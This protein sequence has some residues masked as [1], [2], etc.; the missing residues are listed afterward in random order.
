MGF[1]PLGVF[2]WPSARPLGVVE[3]QEATNINRLA[4]RIENVRGSL[5][6]NAQSVVGASQLGI[7]DTLQVRRA[8]QGLTTQDNWSRASSLET[9]SGLRLPFG[10]SVKINSNE[11][12]TERSGSSQDR[13]RVQRE[14]RFPRFNLNWGRAD[15]IPYIK[16]VI[17]S[18]QVNANWEKS[19]TSEGEGSL[20]RHNLITEGGSDEVRVSWN[21]RWRW[22]PTTTIEHVV[23]NAISTDFE[24]TSVESDSTAIDRPPRGR[25]ENKRSSTTFKVTYTL[26]PRSLPLFG[27]LKSDISLNFEFGLEDETR[28]NATGEEK[29]TEI[30]ATDRWRTQLSLSYSFSENFRGEGLIRI[31]NNDNRLTDKTRKSR[32]LRLSGTFYLR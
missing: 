19:Q 12:T 23:S 15:R 4:R 31:E 17:N 18:A 3:A 25:S 28:S 32:E 8:T 5:G 6:T 9:S 21:G 16:K 10:I 22:G 29:L 27:K 13:L 2:D 20:E 24:L 11:Q 1:G 26:K 30:S 7:D 14:R